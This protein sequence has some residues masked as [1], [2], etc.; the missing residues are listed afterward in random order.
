MKINHSSTVATLRGTVTDA[1]LSQV[2]GS[3]V[4]NIGQYVQ[5]RYTLSNSGPIILL[6]LNMPGSPGF[7]GAF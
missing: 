7:T 1:A 6:D 2:A 4:S 5:V 3:E